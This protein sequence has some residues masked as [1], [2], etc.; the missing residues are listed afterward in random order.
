MRATVVATGRKTVE[1]TVEHLQWE[2]EHQH[3]ATGIPPMAWSFS[4]GTQIIDVAMGARAES[5]NGLRT[6][7][8]KRQPANTSTAVRA[9]CIRRTPR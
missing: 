5:D 2:E 1:V 4:P 9:A 8:P 7:L 6:S 3:D